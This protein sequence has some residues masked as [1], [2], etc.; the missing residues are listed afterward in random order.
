MPAQGHIAC[1]AW[2]EKKENKTPT[3]NKDQ[4]EHKDEYKDEDEDKDR[5]EEKDRKE[6]RIDKGPGEKKL[7]SR[8]RSR[9]TSPRRLR[10]H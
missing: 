1:K 8:I 4:N 6:Q 9:V 5:R 2:I 10:F 3:K 7:K